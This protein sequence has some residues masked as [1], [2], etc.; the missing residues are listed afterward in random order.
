ML[1]LLI[2][3]AGDPTPTDNSVV[4]GPWGAAIFVFL[5]LAV[6]VLGWSFSRQLKKVRKAQEE[7]V[8]GEPDASEAP[9]APESDQPAAPDAE[10]KNA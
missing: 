3:A 7:G 2:A 4:A 1:P 9:D 10:H 8:Y 6:V 5:L